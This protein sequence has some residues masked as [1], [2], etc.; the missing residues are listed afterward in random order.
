MKFP[1]KYR[2]GQKDIVKDIEEALENRIHMVFEA[3]TGSGKTLATLYPAVKYAIKNNKKV[4]YLVHTNSQERQVIK[5]AKKLGIRA[6]ALQGRANLCPLARERNEL[7]HGSPDELALLC[8]KLKKDVIEGNENACIYYA[9]Y[10]KNGN[11]IRKIIEESPTAEEFFEKAMN[12]KICAYEAIKDALPD[13]TVIVFPYIYFF[14][15]FI[16]RGIMD[17]IGVPMQDIILIV[18][19]AHNIPDFARELKSME[20]SVNSLENMEK[21]ALDYGNPQVLGH[22]IADI[23]EFLKE[24]IYKMQK[25]VEDEEGIIPHYAFEEEVSNVFG[26]SINDFDILAKDLIYYGE[27]VRENKVKHRKLPRSYMYHTGSFLYFWREAYSYEY[28]RLIKWGKT[29]SLEVYCLDPATVTDA[30]LNV[31]SSIHLSGTL[32]PDEYKNIVALPDNTITKRYPSPFPKENLKILYVDDVTTKYGEVDENLTRIAKHL[33]KIISIGKNTAIF[34][35]SYSLLS[36]IK[37]LLDSKIL[38]EERGM[39][40]YSL[41]QM[42]E[43]F[44][45]KGGSILSVIGGRIFEGLDFPGK[46]LEIVVI[47]GIPYPKPTPKVKALQRYYDSKFGNG[48]GYVFRMPALI[49]MRQ[50]IGRLIRSEEDRGIAIILDKRAASFKGDLPLE[51]VENLV[52]EIREFFKE[53]EK[54]EEGRHRET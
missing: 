1:Y 31:H 7:Q 15:P 36:K 26:I 47:V 54:G 13:A 17:K 19:E 34:F 18:D 29:P 8:N 45:E 51:K 30:L 20:L 5:E 46:L 32:V 35:P 2:K 44:K 40:T 39:K 10:L 38:S 21:E 50:A 12:L 37:E 52:K 4:I 53:N 28:I 22:S 49:K 9:N 25:F 6:I 43:N 33:T 11:D 41:F 23:A 48:W 42:I 24:A 14:F 3:P 27:M 16:R